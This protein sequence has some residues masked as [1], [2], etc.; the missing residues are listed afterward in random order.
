RKK[1]LERRRVV[2]DGTTVT[3]SEADGTEAA[4]VFTLTPADADAL[5]SGAL[6]LSV[7]FMRGTAKMAGDF[8]VL[9]HVLPVLSGAQLF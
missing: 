2:V 9:L 6:D 1:E 3:P 5:K 7:A 8:G 4:V